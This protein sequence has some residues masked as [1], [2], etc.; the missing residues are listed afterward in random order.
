MGR[1]NRHRARASFHRH[2]AYPRPLADACCRMPAPSLGER[3]RGRANVRWRSRRGLARVQIGG[4]VATPILITGQLI[5]QLKINNTSRM[6]WRA[7]LG[8]AIA[9]YSDARS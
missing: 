3:C 1:F 4:T 6:R 7:M 9:P 5:A 2:H 8:D